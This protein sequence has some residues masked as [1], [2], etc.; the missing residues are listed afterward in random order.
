MT[1]PGMPD[2]AQP[3]RYVTV[4]ADES[5]MVIKGGPFLWDGRASWSAPGCPPHNL[6]YEQEALDMGYTYPVP[7]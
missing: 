3:G 2:E 7:K 5:D 6:M 1:M 4:S